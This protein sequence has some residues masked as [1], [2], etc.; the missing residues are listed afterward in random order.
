MWP[1]LL[2]SSACLPAAA[3][4][5]EPVVDLGPVRVP[6]LHGSIAHTTRAAVEAAYLRNEAGGRWVLGLDTVMA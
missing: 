2:P 5:P 6:V 1:P 3:L 4:G